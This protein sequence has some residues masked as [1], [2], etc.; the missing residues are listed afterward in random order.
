MNKR[1]YVVGLFLTL[2]LF[3]AFV[4]FFLE[5]K[6]GPQITYEQKTNENQEQ[7]GEED[8]KQKVDRPEY[9]NLDDTQI[10]I[11]DRAIAVLF[12]TVE[13]LILSDIKVASFEEKEFSDASLGCPKEGEV[14]AQVVTAGY[15]IVLE[16]KES[17]YDYR[18]AKSSESV[19]LCDN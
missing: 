4:Y 15:Q 12:N 18:L 5:P 19:V 2:A 3:S 9:G 6:F 8:T 17:K 10:K 14:Y 7:L 11:V 1:Q 13:D 16:T